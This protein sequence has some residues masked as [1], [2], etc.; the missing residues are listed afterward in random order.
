MTTETI[1]F[2][3]LPHILK[4]RTIAYIRYEGVVLFA[5][6]SLNPKD[7]YSRAEGR[8][9]SAARLNDYHDLL[10]HTF[11]THAGDINKSVMIVADDRVGYIG[12][13]AVREYADLT[14]IIA[15]HVTLNL[16]DFKHA[17]ITSLINRAV[18]ETVDE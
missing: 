18:A 13:A 8:K 2:I 12:N 14:A 5:W 16:K 15:D 17:F 4:P 10:D 6:A 3:H 1:R 11:N 9:Q 7:Q